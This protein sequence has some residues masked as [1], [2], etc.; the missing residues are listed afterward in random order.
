MRSVCAGGLAT[1]TLLLLLLLLLGGKRV[2]IGC[3][4]GFVPPI[5]APS[6][7]GFGRGAVGNGRAGNAKGQRGPK[8]GGRS[9][10]RPRAPLPA[11]S[12]GTPQEPEQLLFVGVR[13]GV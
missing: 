11:A 9:L 3:R 7:Q 4:C 12:A 2:V 10:N 6:I 1:K 5:V 13:F 8:V